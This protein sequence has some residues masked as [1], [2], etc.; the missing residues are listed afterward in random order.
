MSFFFFPYCSLIHKEEVGLCVSFLRIDCEFVP[1]INK[2]S[3]WFYILV[4]GFLL[5]G[6]L[7]LRGRKSEYQISILSVH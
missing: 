2:V 5:R 6:K 4:F 1:V 3:I 7:I